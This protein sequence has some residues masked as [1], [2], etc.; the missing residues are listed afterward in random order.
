MPQLV[1]RRLPDACCCLLSPFSSALTRTHNIWRLKEFSS[2]KEA[3]PFPLQLSPAQTM[4]VPTSSS[5]SSLHTLDSVSG[6]MNSE[7][8]FAA[9]QPPRRT[10]SVDRNPVVAAMITSNTLRDCG[11]VEEMVSKCV[12]SGNHKTVMCE[13]AQRYLLNCKGI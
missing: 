8:G 7:Q 10:T 11:Q 3:L 6:E 12:G 2:K 13:T 5:F 4:P 1:L 9:P